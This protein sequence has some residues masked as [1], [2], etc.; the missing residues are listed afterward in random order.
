MLSIRSLVKKLSILSIAAVLSSC[1]V[2]KA[3]DQPD[4]KD[5]RVLN[6]GTERSRVIAELGRP[7]DSRMKNGHREDIFTFVQGYSKANKT[8]RAL[9]HG[10]ADVYTLGLWE[11]IGTPIEGVNNGKKMQVVVSYNN[12]DRVSNVNVLKG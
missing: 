11:V 1:A 8:L 9:G 7:V 12:K 4:K 6:Q 3:V 10:V 2:V 5:L